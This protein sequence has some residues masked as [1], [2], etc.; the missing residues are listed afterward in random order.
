LRDLR[1]AFS[2]VS[3]TEESYLIPLAA[4]KLAV[5]DI[6]WGTP[7][8]VKVWRLLIGYPTP[9]RWPYAKKNWN[10]GS[11]RKSAPRGGFSARGG[12]RRK[13]SPRGKG[14][15]RPLGDM[16]QQEMADECVYRGP[17]AVRRMRRYRPRGKVGH[18]EVGEDGLRAGEDGRRGLV[19]L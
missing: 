8:E 11:L 4:N 5:T 18:G 16:H 19:H 12:Y 17:A 14:A 10:K 13:R 15:M 7:E 3:W 9:R 6:W 1:D 2:R